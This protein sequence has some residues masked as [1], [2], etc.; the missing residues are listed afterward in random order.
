[1]PGVSETIFKLIEFE[2]PEL[3]AY[4]EKELGFGW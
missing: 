1:M 2:R 3:S 4:I